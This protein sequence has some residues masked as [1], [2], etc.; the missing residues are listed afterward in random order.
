[1]RSV[2]ET[3][4]ASLSRLNRIE[5]GHAHPVEQAS[6]PDFAARRAAITFSVIANNNNMVLGAVTYTFLTTLGS[7]GANVV[8]VKIQGTLTD[9]VKKLAEAT[10]GVVDAANITYGTGTSPHPTC[11]G[12]WTSQR[13][14][15]GATNVPAGQSLFLLER[16]EDVITAITLTS[17]AT[18]TNLTAFTRAGFLRY[19]LN[20]NAAGAGGVNSIRSAMHTILPIGSV[21]LGG[22]AAP[23]GLVA[24]DVHGISLTDQS[25]SDEKEVDLYFSSDE[26]TFTRLS[27]SNSVGTS[28]TSAATHVNFIV[29]GMRIPKGNG[30]YCK[31]GSAGTSAAATVD[32]K[33]TYHMY[34]IELS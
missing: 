29:K 31:I 26:V 2:I 22:L 9:T 21:L 12:F 28:T 18:T 34:S 33:F 16:A 24:F 5:L 25:S 11:I 20:G 10:R 4:Y 32:L 8:H 15:I 6:A 1:M 13:F 30:L 14:A 3:V 7:P 19:I 17:T 23:L 27:R